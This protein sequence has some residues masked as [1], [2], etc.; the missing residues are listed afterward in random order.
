[1]MAKSFEQK[2]KD[3]ARLIIEVGIN[4]QEGKP[5]GI[6][7]PV[8]AYKFVRELTR[9]A[10]ERGA[11]DVTFN[12]YDDP[13][14]RLKYEHAPLSEFEIFPDWAVQRGHYEGERGTGRISVVANDPELLTGIDPEKIEA[15]NK[16]RAI[17]MKDVVKYSMNDINSWCVVA[18][19]S[20]A[21]AEK[22]FP[23]LEGQAAVDAL[24]EAI[25][26]AC[27]IDLEDPVAAWKEHLAS[28]KSHADYLNEKKFLAFHY[29]SDNG[30]DLRVGLPEGHIWISGDSVNSHGDTFVANMPT[31]E[32]F[33][34]PDA[35][36]VDGILKSSKPLVYGGN[37]IDRFSLEFKDGAVVNF[38]AEVGEKYLEDMLNV[39]EN[40]RRL[41]EI[42]L[43][44][45]DSPISN[46][47][48][49]F[50]NTLFDENASCHFALGK[51]YP[52]C[53]EGGT[54]LTNEELQER[55][56]NDALIH[57]DFMVGSSSLEITGITA[58]GEEVAIFRDG[59]WAF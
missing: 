29:R 1:M 20:T 13:I 22:V 15:A 52:T 34:A 9:L 16:A 24:W 47:N 12:W 30:T 37:I 38:Q 8:E 11:S 39:D 28:L 3:Y 10:Y 31:E 27:R 18:I 25:F 55:G 14:T 2:L 23:E 19:P 41:G 53:L 32:V 26:K 4:V 46:S 49:L 54:E 44:P 42:A 40:S 43:V 6:S 56:I 45:H 51:A 21:W 59:N 50:F 58:D 36:H 57:E 5:I 17:A 7:A 35:R 48:I 33:T